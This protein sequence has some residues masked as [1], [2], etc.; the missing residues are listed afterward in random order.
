MGKLLEMRNKFSQGWS[1]LSKNKKISYT[2]L[3][4]VI[5][6]ALG[7]FLVATSQTKY[8]V[9]FSNMT[10]EDSGAI[11]TKLDEKKVT[12]KVTGTSIL[13]P[14]E[15]IDSLRMQLMSEVTMTN[16]SQGFEL[17]DTGKMAPT[18]TETKIMYQRAL[19]G[20]I[21]RAIKSFPEIEGAKVNLVL[22]ENTAF[23]REID[24]ASAS[25]VIKLKS[26]TKLDAAQVKAIVALLTGAVEN[27]PKEN[28]S[29]VSDKFA[30]LTE[31]LYDEED[32][33]ATKS[34]GDQQELKAQIEK[35]LEEKIMKVLEPIY[36]DGVK[37]SVNSELDFDA[38]T[39]NSITYDKTKGVIVS[40]NDKESWNGGTST[41]LST[42]PVDAASQNTSPTDT[43]DGV[44]VSKEGT[45]NY[46]NSKTEENLVQAPGAIK[47]ITTSVVLDGNLDQATRASVNNLVAQATGYSGDRGDTISIEGLNFDATSKKAAEQ[48]LLDIENA[49]TAAAKKLL[50]TRIA[51]G[52][53]AIMLFIIVIVVLRRSSKKADDVPMGID[54][55]IGD[56]IIP[57]V[58]EPYEPIEFGGKS[59][60]TQ[61]EDDVKKYASEKPEQVADI[62]KSW[63]TED[64]RG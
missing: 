16:G 29:I 47:K 32:K 17:F 33:T 54:R 26:G 46:E 4:A 25:V 64:E 41:G 20:E 5:I 18:D 14:K 58:D 43:K 37:V 12:Y 61:M 51:Y 31:G 3:A 1:N 21:E 42:S 8:D 63:L 27:L 60:K 57:K 49:D 59:K 48:A 53:G 44:I 11:L 6:I 28:V 2:I 13:V 40:S 56:N 36:K 22:P 45:K 9:L 34:T 24:P 30:L 7:S 35:A 38:I 52:V 62:I 23:V 55:V 39:R 50:Y 10:E 15:Q 19:A